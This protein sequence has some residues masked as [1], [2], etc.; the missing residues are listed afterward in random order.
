MKFLITER[1]LHFYF[2]LNIHQYNVYYVL[3][4]ASLIESTNMIP[5][6]DPSSIKGTIIM[7]ITTTYL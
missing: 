7:S 6:Y 5:S 2:F 1:S 4:L 3:H